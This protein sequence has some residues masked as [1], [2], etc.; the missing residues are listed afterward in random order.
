MPFSSLQEGQTRNENRI[1]FRNFF[2]GFSFNIL[3]YGPSN[4]FQLQ[5]FLRMHLR[6]A[7]FW[8]INERVICLFVFGATAP[9]GPGRPHSRGFIDH[10]HQRATI[11]RTP[12]DE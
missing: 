7:L 10:T 4:L 5:N 8:V 1:E 11:G 3:Q 9:S 2:N 6:T 12:L